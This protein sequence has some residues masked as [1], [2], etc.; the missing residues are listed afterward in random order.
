MLI[1]HNARWLGVTFIAK[2]K[3]WIIGKQ[4]TILPIGPECYGLLHCVRNDVAE[5]NR[6]KNYYCG[7]KA[8]ERANLTKGIRKWQIALAKGPHNDGQAR[9]SFNALHIPFFC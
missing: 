7:R 2:R 9:L 1:Y 6:Q 4:W 5:N 8:M 3:V